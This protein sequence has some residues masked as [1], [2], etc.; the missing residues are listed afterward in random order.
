MYMH[1]LAI[2]KDNFAVQELI[3]VTSITVSGTNYV[4]VNNGITFTYDSSTHYL[5]IVW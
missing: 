1:V 4:V 2:A 3:R 5:Q